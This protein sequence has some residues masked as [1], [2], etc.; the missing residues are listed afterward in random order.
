MAAYWAINIIF[1]RYLF[2]V[3]QAIGQL[4]KRACLS[5]QPLFVVFAWFNVRQ[6]S[7]GYIDVSVWERKYQLRG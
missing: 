2:F 5:A 3:G 4:A 6:H 1:C 7:N